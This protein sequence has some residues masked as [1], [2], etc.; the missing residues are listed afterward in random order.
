VSEP[1]LYVCPHCGEEVDTSPDPGGGSEQQYVED[2]P[3]CCRPNMIF[4]S[5]SPDDDGYFINATAE[6]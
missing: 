3:V 4:A 1:G 5:Y 6:V 2:C